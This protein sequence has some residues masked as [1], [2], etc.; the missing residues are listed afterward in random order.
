[1]AVNPKITGTKPRDISILYHLW[2]KVSLTTSHIQKLCFQGLGR[3]S[4][5]KSISTLKQRGFVQASTY[6]FGR[7]GKLEDLQFLTRK[8]FQQLQQSCIAELEEAKF[9]TKNAPQLIVDYA[10]RVAIID[11]WISLELD[12]QRQE[13]FELALFVP[14]HK[15][16]EN[17][18][19]ITLKCILP[20][21][22]LISVRNDGLFI[23]RDRQ[24]EL[25]YLFLLEIDRGTMPVTMSESLREALQNNIA[26]RAN[27][28]SKVLK[29]QTVFAHWHEA[30]KG[31]GKRFKHFDG[32]RVVIITS[33]S[34]RVL[35]IFEQL[36][37]PRSAFLISHF[38]EISSG[39]FNGKYVISLGEDCKRMKT[40][41]LNQ[42]F[43]NSL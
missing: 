42:V 41:H 25:E 21:G 11:Y 39:A 35:N 16:L 20:N 37:P 8:G 6:D 15:K 23:I 36:P 38:N 30:T 3:D 32:A 9:L 13:H 12:I 34:Q 1:M 31:L 5:Y 43:S 22:N 27:L 33:S 28:E 26:I 40:T 4:V 7:K 18:N 24:T 14:E 19:N 17:G 2:D 29:I 10:H